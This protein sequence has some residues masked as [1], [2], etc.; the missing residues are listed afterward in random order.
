MVFFT[1]EQ[2]VFEGLGVAA[3]FVK[4]GGEGIGL[5]FG[6]AAFGLDSQEVGHAA[7]FGGGDKVGVVARGFPA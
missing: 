2:E 7:G 3:V 4:Q 1:G 5:A 6:V